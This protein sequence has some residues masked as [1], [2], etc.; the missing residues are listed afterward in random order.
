MTLKELITRVVEGRQGCK[1]TEVVVFMLEHVQS[2]P[3]DEPEEGI[4]PS[5]LLPAL[6]EMVRDGELCEV[7]Y[8][9]PD[10]EYRLKSFL[11][12]KD[13]QVSVRISST[14]QIEE[15]KK[16][17]LLCACNKTR[18]P[19]GPPPGTTIIDGVVHGYDDCRSLRTQT[20]TEI[21]ETD[22][23]GNAHSLYEITIGSWVIA[24]GGT[25]MPGSYENEEAARL[26]FDFDDD[27]LSRLQEEVNEAAANPD[28]RLITLVML[29]EAKL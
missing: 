16:N 8:T 24:S 18:V 27:T 1:A 14:R 21:H 29:R 9:L 11:L 15:N 23:D 5:T 17:G 26:A 12:P 13:T 3:E 19:Y 20:K 4:A 28:D 6:E 7:E 22:E 2:Y 10:M 25:W